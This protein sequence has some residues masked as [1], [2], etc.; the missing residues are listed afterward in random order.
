M[1]NINIPVECHNYKIVVK[2]TV[3]DL[4]LSDSK[5]V[6]LLKKISV[7]KQFIDDDK[8]KIIFSVEFDADDHAH[9]FNQ[10]LDTCNLSIE[11]LTDALNNA[12]DFF[13]DYTVT[14]NS[15]NKIDKYVRSL[16]HY[17]NVWRGLT[18]K[19]DYNLCLFKTRM[20]PYFNLE[21]KDWV[22][23]NLDAMKQNYPAM[24]L[25][26][27]SDKKDESDDFEEEL[28]MASKNNNF[29]EWSILPVEEYPNMDK[30]V[31][32]ILTFDKLG[33][34]RQAHI[35]FLRLLLSP[36]ECHIIK[37][38]RIWKIIKP[39]MRKSKDFEELVRYCC[40]YAM[41]ILKQE[42]T[43]MFSQVNQRYRVLFTLDEAANLPI[44]EHAHMERD[45]YILQL[46]D[47]TRLSETMPFY[48]RIGRRIN[49]N[50]E[51]QRRF[52]LATGG[53]FKG[54]NLKALG[55][56]VTGSI[57]IPCVHTSP[58]EEGF[59]DVDWNRERLNIDVP[60][61]YMVDT[62]ENA[63]DMAF[64]NYLEYYYPSYCSLT[65]TEYKSQ[66]LKQKLNILPLAQENNISYDTDEASNTIELASLDRAE[67]QNL[68]KDILE[69]NTDMP[70]N[71]SN[72][73]E[74]ND[75]NTELEDSIEKKSKILSNIKNKKANKHTGNLPREDKSKPR[76][77]YNQ[78]ADIDLSITT[79]DTN[80][81]QTNAMIL[82]EKIKENCKHRGEVYI[83]E[84]KTIASIKYKVFGPGLPRPMDIFRIPYDP[85]K[86][87]KKFHVHAVKMYYDNEVTLFRSCVS[88]LLS[89][90]GENYKWFSCNK[91]PVD[92]LLK[93][94]QRGF[95]II[96]N[97]NERDGI[98]NYIQ[99]NNRWGD[100]L[101]HLGIEPTKIFCCITKNHGFFAPGLYDCGVR[102]GLRSFNK[103][104]NNVYAS[105]LVISL[106]KSLFPYGELIVKDNKKYYP[107]VTN[108]ITGC[109]EYIDREQEASNE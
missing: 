87:V 39:E 93:Y 67:Y 69:E 10:L 83:Q 32:R 7:N 104:A 44:F 102:L 91:V 50:E 17:D 40:S 47:D 24:M 21:C 96:L 51:F 84:V 41:Y 58:L 61:P 22:K 71:K 88:C 94:C 28:S 37:E 55:A 64:L 78:L 66:V 31:S 4:H 95:S 107:P 5:Y 38:S 6:K 53:A 8:Q 20:L 54:V 108:M 19:P 34:S 42:E 85:A 92:V 63:E 26:N 27:T 48:L 101:E 106:P 3:Y 25:R 76:I 65:D 2:N 73:E 68:D 56:A 13:V 36:K 81:F 62:P 82:F 30:L 9:I 79:R 98:S 100:L 80:T 29:L 74:L 109:L 11:E 90:V 18:N 45:P 72:V 86:M 49:N 33:M 46:T 43:I 14:G 15:L 60:Y 97:K 103:D 59:E 77:E 12:Y 89:G 52:N 70:K 35:M 57:L 99:T 75:S 16:G 105:N 23:A 1:N